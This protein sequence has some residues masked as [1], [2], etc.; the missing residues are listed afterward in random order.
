MFK[1]TPNI[2]SAIAQHRIAAIAIAL[3]CMYSILYG[4]CVAL[5]R[6]RMSHFLNGQIPPAL[7]S[8]GLHSESSNLVEFFLDS[9]IKN[10]FY[11]TQVYLG[12]DIWV[13][14]SETH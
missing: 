3:H 1:I 14:V 6:D 5:Q 9:D 13:R 2:A 4:T 8:H 7:P 10:I 12:S 11:L